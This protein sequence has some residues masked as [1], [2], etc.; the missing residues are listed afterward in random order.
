MKLHDVFRSVLAHFSRN[1]MESGSRT[2]SSWRRCEE[3]STLRIWLRE[4]LICPNV[5]ATGY[6]GADSTRGR[7]MSLRPGLLSRTSWAS[8]TSRSS[9]WSAH[10]TLVFHIYNL[11][12]DDSFI[13]VDFTGTQRFDQE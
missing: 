13:S 4:C 9:E 8:S 1:V 10:N 11:A 3:I 12:C 7:I 5:H 2:L 6:S